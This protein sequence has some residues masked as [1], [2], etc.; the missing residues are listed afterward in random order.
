MNSLTTSI[1]KPFLLEQ[2]IKKVVGVYAGRFQPFG[3]HHYKTFKW[4]QKTFGTKHS[5]IGTSNKTGPKSPFTFKEKS[6]II[7]KY[8]I[9]TNKVIQV[10][11]PYVAQEITSKYNDSTSAV[12]F[13]V[14]EKDAARLKAGKYFLPYKQNKNNYLRVQNLLREKK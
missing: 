9:P 4:V 5:F 7:R 1:I 8:K 11:N 13:V 3:L 12:V 2:N 10:K 14:G 6:N